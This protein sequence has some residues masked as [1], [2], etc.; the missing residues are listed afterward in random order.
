MV[1]LYPKVKCFFL[2]LV[3][4]VSA[5]ASVKAQDFIIKN[6]K[7]EIQAKVLEITDETIKY[8]QFQFQDGPVYN[9]KKTEV[10]MII[11]QNGKRETF[12]VSE[13]AQVVGNNEPVK[14]DPK[15]TQIL[16]QKTKREF[17]KNPSRIMLGFGGYKQDGY[18]EKA[19][20]AGYEKVCGNSIFYS[21]FGIAS[22]NFVDMFWI[23]YNNMVESPGG[24]RTDDGSGTSTIETIYGS[25]HY[26]SGYVF[27]EFDTR[28][29]SAGVLAGP[30]LNFTRGA[31]SLQTW[32]AS[33]KTYSYPVNDVEASFFTVGLHTGL[34]LHKYLSTNKKGQKNLFMRLSFEQFVM[35]KGSYGSVL[36]LSFGL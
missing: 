3:F 14:V 31:Y 2:F 5:N 25:K 29:I 11:Y 21:G 13:K 19:P 12:T 36:A 15:P 8:K 7:S 35:A 23:R 6:D 24:G 28:F 9:V 1:K 16:E 4:L 20:K 17:L 26:L 18:S 33:K 32:D 22:N 34:Y 30:G 27:K 10:F